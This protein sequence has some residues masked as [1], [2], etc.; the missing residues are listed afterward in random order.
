MS[1]FSLND[2]TKK[3]EDDAPVPKKAKQNEPQRNA[4][5]QPELPA[6]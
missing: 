4:I 6:L 2:V 5:G 1:Y 3:M